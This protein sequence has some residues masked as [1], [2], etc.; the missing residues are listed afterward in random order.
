MSRTHHSTLLTPSTPVKVRMGTLRRTAIGSTQ[1]PR[2]RP[3]SQAACW[4]RALN[5]EANG[6][7]DP[8]AWFVRHRVR[9]EFAN[10]AN[11]DVYDLERLRSAASTPSPQSDSP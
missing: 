10:Q 4:A 9:T 2:Q 3:N 6:R 5:T 11:G 8:L 7:S 1:T